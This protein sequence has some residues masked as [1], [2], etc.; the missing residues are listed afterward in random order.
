MPT[1]EKPVVIVGA[2]IG[3]LAV[4]RSLLANGIGCTIVEKENRL[5]GKVRD[6]ACMATNQC[7]RCFC[8]SV[9]DLVEEVNSFSNAKVMKN[10]ELSS[11]AASSEGIR[12]GITSLAGDANGLLEAEALVVATGFQPYDPSEKLFWGYG[13]LEGVLTLK[14]MDV[15]VRN[16]D[17]GAF[18]T[19]IP[20]DA[21]IAFFQCVGS[22]DAAIGANYCSQ[23]CC[24]AALRMALK[25]RQEREDWE[26]TIFY[27]D[28]QVAGKFAG[29]LLEA[30]RANR[31]R[32]VQG[33]PGEIVQGDNDMLQIIREDA[34]RNVRENFHRIIL[35]IGQR[36][37]PDAPRVAEMAGVEMN[38]FG[39]FSSKDPLG[40][41]RTGTARIYVA[42][43]CGGPKDIEETLMDGGQTAAAIISDLFGKGS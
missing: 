24:E 22:R 11:V 33:V 35:S 14:D 2:G 12:I 1:S 20:D 5:G 27:I 43:T 21:K 34:G 36:P 9:G 6:W 25:L 15:Y 13:R 26:I 4:A 7:L 3:G 30:A 32:L 39:F 31:I 42:G 37:S 19:G 18:S 40:G 29:S 16:D 17:L 10:A 41:G 23:Y 28:L 8:C 38:E